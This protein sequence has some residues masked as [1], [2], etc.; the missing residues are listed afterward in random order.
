MDPHRIAEERSIAMHRVV[1]QRICEDH[2][3]LERARMR[4][5]DWIETDAVHPRYATEWAALLEKPVGEIARLL[6]DPGETA[7]AMRQCSPFAGAIDSATRWRIWREVRT[8]VAKEDV[9]P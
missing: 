3:L 7:R 5:R 8:R 4:V 9:L 2:D 6:V 1:A